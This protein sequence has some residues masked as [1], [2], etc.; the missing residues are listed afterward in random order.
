[1]M[2]II[3]KWK[4]AKL[5]ACLL[6][7]AIGGQLFAEV[8]PSINASGVTTASFRNNTSQAWRLGG[9]RYTTNGGQWIAIDNW[10]C[11]QNQIRRVPGANNEVDI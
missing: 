3:K 9:V 6:A 1:M 10:L 4:F 5:V 8:V 11:S 2:K 7:F